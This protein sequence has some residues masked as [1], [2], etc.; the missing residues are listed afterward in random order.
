[1]TLLEKLDLVNKELRKEL[2]KEVKVLGRSY[3]TTLY[4]INKL[5]KQEIKYYI[6]WKIY[7]STSDRDIEQYQDN[8]K[9]DVYA[10]W[11]LTKEQLDKTTTI[12]SKYFKVDKPHSITDAIHIKYEV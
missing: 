7:T 1:M 6:V 10:S 8:S 2:G 11:N 3:D 12:L 9:K 5:E 4:T